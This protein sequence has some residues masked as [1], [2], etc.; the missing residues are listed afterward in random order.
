MTPT[1]ERAPQ[2]VIWISQDGRLVWLPS[3]FDTPYIPRSEYE[4]MRDRYERAVELM[5]RIASSGIEHDHKALDY[6]TVQIDR[7]DWDELRL[8]TE[9]ASDG[10]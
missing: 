6:L 5:R 3:P 7:S 4:A 2:N 10:R 1:P 8:T 9:D